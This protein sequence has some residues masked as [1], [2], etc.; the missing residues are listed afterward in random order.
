MESC[1]KSRE[2]GGKA[3]HEN[4]GGTVNVGNWGRGGGFSGRRTN[5]Q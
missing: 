5:E 4:P 2:V 1:G 3:K